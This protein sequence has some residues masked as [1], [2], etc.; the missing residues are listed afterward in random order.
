MVVFI[1]GSREDIDIELV[2]NGLSHHDQLLLYFL[3][4]KKEKAFRGERYIVCL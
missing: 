3:D 2:I 1:D 4:H